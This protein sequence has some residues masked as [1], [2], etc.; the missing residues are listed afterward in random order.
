M[1][2]TLWVP[3]RAVLRF[4]L[5]QFAAVIA[6]I[7]LLQSADDNSVFGRIFEGLDALVDET[8][9]ITATLITVKSFTKSWLT[10]AF[11]IAYTYVACWVILS[12][13]AVAFRRVVDVA[14]RHNFLW[15][16]NSIARQRGISAYRA[17]LPLERI[18]PDHVS[19]Q[20]W[21]ERFAW[22]ADNGPPYQPLGRRLLWAAVIY[23][24][25]VV[26]VLILLQ[27]F[28]PFPVLNWLGA[29]ASR[30]FGF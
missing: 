18:R 26:M 11:M 25:G 22:P 3:F 9:R 10:F 1:I 13:C 8:V 2:K 23:A 27:I 5:V 21:E 7:L 4:P 19:Q 20:A 12:L 15:L 14:G 17:W 30:L 28:S 24:S 16:R 29:A 6:L